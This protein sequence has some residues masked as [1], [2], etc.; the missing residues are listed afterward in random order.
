MV[1]PAELHEV[2]QLLMAH[3]T[4]IADLPQERNVAL[5]VDDQAIFGVSHQP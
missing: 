4:R 5:R 3:E 1:E 2:K